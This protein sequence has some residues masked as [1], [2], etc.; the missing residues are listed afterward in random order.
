M[1]AVI[2][3]GGKGLRMKEVTDDIPKPLAYIGDKP[4]LWHIMKMYSSF[5]INDFILLLGYKGEKI[6]EYFMD[7]RWKNNS[8]TL[9]TNDG[10]YDLIDAP[11][12]WNITFVDTGINTMT[13]G[14]IKKAEPFIKDESFMLTYGDGVADINL[15]VLLSFHKDMGKLATVTG[16][17]KKSRYGILNVENHIATSFEEKSTVEGIINGGFFILDKKVF[18]Y[19]ENDENCIFEQ[20]PLKQLTEIKQLAVYQHNGFWMA[21][22]T[23]KELSDINDNWNQGNAPWKIW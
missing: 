1:K 14:R 6:K 2:L 4:I 13:G 20:T 12:N 21:I 3:C 22:D 23:Y 7:Y 17:P 15:D 19:I 11:E 5:G 8:F 18:D 16:I 9:N 10:Q